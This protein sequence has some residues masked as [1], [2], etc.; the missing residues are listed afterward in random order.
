MARTREA[1]VSGV[2][3]ISGEEK[4]L[5]RGG[6]AR[7]SA[8]CAS[9]RA[10]DSGFDAAPHHRRVPSGSPG[11][12][13][14]ERPQPQVR[15]QGLNPARRVLFGHQSRIHRY[16]HTPLR[17]V[18]QPCTQ[19]CSTRPG[20]ASRPQRARSRRSISA[21]A[22]VTRAAH[23]SHTHTHSYHAM[24]CFSLAHLSPPCVRLGYS[25]PRRLLSHERPNRKTER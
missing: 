9:A 20:P 4:G 25:R 22:R 24:R 16:R 15:W 3:V 11:A 2:R 23:A 7:A 21:S 5:R 17:Q 18:S 19:Q 12:R 10:R 6:R 8:G 1:D 13:H 14:A